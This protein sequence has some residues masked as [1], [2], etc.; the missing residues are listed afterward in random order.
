M[1][2]SAHSLI[3][4]KVHDWHDTLLESVALTFTSGS[5][6]SVSLVTCTGEAPRSAGTCSIRVTVVSG[7]IGTLINDFGGEKHR[8]TFVKFL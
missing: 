7:R 4:D 1:V 2:A 3:S 5:I 6:S 8:V